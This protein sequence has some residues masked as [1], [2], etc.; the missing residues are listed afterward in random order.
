[1]QTEKPLGSREV[2]MENKNKNNLCGMNIFIEN[3][4][5]NIKH[6]ENTKNYEKYKI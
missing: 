1:M 3:W 6:I 5:I 4:K 2:T